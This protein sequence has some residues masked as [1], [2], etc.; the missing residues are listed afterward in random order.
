MDKII[1]SAIDNLALS[2]SALKKDVEIIKKIANACI[3]ALSNK[4]KIIFIGNGGSAADSQHLAAEFVGRFKKNR[5]PLAALALTTDTSVLTAIGNDFSFEDIFVKQVESLAQKE[6]L[7]FCFSTSGN[8][9][10]IIKAVQFCR[11]KKIKTVGLLGNEGGALRNLVD[12]SLCIRG[13]T[14]RIQETHILIGH[15][16]C[17][18]I[19]E[20]FF[21]KN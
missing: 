3:F 20:S 8:S 14:P 6:D 19:E 4:G 5:P 13:Q 10:N 9:K 17:E 2:L 11:S 18:I 16:I 7:V 21:G 12:I 15:I 1:L